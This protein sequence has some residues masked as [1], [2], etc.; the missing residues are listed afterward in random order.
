MYINAKKILKRFACVSMLCGTLLLTGCYDKIPENYKTNAQARIAQNTEYLEKMAELGFITDKQA[1][2][3]A[4]AF[5]DTLMNKL[6]SIVNSDGTVNPNGDFKAIMNSLRRVRNSPENNVA[7]YFI[8]QQNFTGNSDISVEQAFG[9]GD[10]QTAFKEIAKMEVY[11]LKPFTQGRDFDTLMKAITEYENSKK[12]KNAYAQYL[13][14]YFSRLV[15]ENNNPFLIKLPDPVTV[16]KPNSGDSNEFNK[17]FIVYGYHDTGEVDDDGNT[18]Y[19]IVPALDIALYEVNKEFIDVVSDIGDNTSQD[20]LFHRDSSGGVRALILTYPVAYIDKMEYVPA[21]DPKTFA[22]QT[23]SDQYMPVLAQSDSIYI[24]IRDGKLKK[25][26]NTVNNMPV[27]EDITYKGVNILPATISDAQG[28]ASYRSSNSE[29]SDLAGGAFVLS[30]NMKTTLTIALQKTDGTVIQ[31][32][33]YTNVTFEMGSILLR[34]YMEVQYMDDVVNGEDWVV[35]GRKFRFQTFVGTGDTVWARYIDNAGYPYPDTYMPGLMISDFLSPNSKEEGVDTNLKFHQYGKE[36]EGSDDVTYINNGMLA[37]P[38]PISS[39]KYVSPN[40]TAVKANIMS[41]DYKETDKT[42]RPVLFGIKTD[43]NLFETKM[44]TDWIGGE[45]VNNSL[46]WWDTWLTDNGFSYQ[47]DNNHMSNFFVGNFGY[48]DIEEGTIYFDMETLRRLQEDIENRQDQNYA[49][50]IN[51]LFIGIGTFMMFYGLLLIVAWVFD[52][53]ILFG[54]KLLGLLT[55]GR[56]VAVSSKE[57][58]DDIS[59]SVH[60]VTLKNVVGS[61]LVVACIGVFLVTFNVLELLRVFIGIVSSI[62][63]TLEGYFFK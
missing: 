11:V 9:V 60:F 40:G 55:L 24:N 36:G 10:F 26:V 25:L 58:A 16:T 2:D 54:P 32:Q 15:D 37:F 61:A 22:G 13:E 43:K 47:V 20:Y 52:V 57:E 27:Y 28:N 3:A 23:V 14:P 44:Y 1:S 21:S 39:G 19:E 49:T 30:D 59:S 12:D 53:N 62:A 7:S 48:A 18:I 41:V 45:D 8:N 33:V 34:D 35:T 17:D 42:P 50:F 56:W 5:E 51:T 4:K 29:N 63:T 31:D 6:S 38:L 46:A